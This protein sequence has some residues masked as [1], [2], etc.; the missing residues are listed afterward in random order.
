MSHEMA[1][2]A[3]PTIV[4]L[5]MKSRRTISTRERAMMMI[6]SDEIEMPPNDPCDVWE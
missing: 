2:M 1:R 6:C 5:T 3:M 4:R